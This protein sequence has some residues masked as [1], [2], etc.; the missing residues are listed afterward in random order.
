MN[1]LEI[2]VTNITKVVGGLPYDSVRI[3]AD[4]EDDGGKEVQVT[5]ILTKFQYDQIRA[6]GFY[7]G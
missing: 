3:T 1:L 4:F 2:Y 5:K 6:W 7:L